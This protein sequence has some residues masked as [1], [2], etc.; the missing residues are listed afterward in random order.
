[1]NPQRYPA[2]YLSAWWLCVVTLPWYI[3]SNS[4][5][6]VLL[7]VVWLA[8]GNFRQK[9]DR[10]RENRWVWPFVIFFL[11]HALG[12]LY[13]ENLSSGLFELEKKLSLVVLPIL[14]A[15]GL[16]LNKASFRTLSNGFIAS[17][18]VLVLASMLGSA[19]ALFQTVKPIQNFDP[20][21]DSLF[22][23]LFP[24]RS[25]AWEYFS[26]IELGKGFDT[27]PSYFSLYLIFCILL[28]LHQIFNSEKVRPF[29][30][31]TL[32]LF[33]FFIALLS[34]RMAVVSLVT[35]VTFAIA[36]NSKGRWMLPTRMAALTC[37]L[38]FLLFSIWINPVS[39]FRIWVEP[40]STQLTFD[41]QTH[42][43]N[44]VNLRLLEW[45]ASSNVIKTSWPIGTGTGDAQAHLENYYAKYDLGIF[46]MAL[47]GHNQYLQTFV[48]LGL[49]GIAALLL[50]FYLPA[51]RAFQ[52]NPLHF[53]F[54]LLFGL[55]CL[56]E[57]MLARQKGIVFFALFQSLFL[58]THS[59]DR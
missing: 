38:A 28:I 5:C 44:S 21:T 35:T 11:L 54:I 40:R 53:M 57:T 24:G 41:N 18:F 1:M 34:S 19:V 6:I 10:W 30:F 56:S 13:S 31:I 36:V 58:I 17:C 23:S 45:S 55:M 37:F 29:Q 47:N 46:H 50:C 52:H 4:V 7:F 49:L 26:Y 20:E 22:H 16:P 39:R 25:E 12:L 48:E 27:H 2:L 51:Y 15:T 43:W 14:A 33:T 8:E 59:D 9:W 42:Y 32:I 3:F